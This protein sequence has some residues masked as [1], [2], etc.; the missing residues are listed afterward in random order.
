MKAKS[1]QMPTLLSDES[2]E[3]FVETA[4]LSTYDLSGLKPMHFEFEPKTAAL[5]MRL[6]ENLLAALKVKAKAKGIPYSRYIRLLLEKDV[7]H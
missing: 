6:P 5:K 1:K 3:R 7:A 4:N 2:A